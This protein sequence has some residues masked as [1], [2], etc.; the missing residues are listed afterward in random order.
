MQKLNIHYEWWAKAGGDSSYK[1]DLPKKEYI[2][3]FNWIDNWLE[4]IFLERLQIH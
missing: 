3:D 4:N 2:K 1:Y